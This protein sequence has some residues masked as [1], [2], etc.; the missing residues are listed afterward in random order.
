MKCAGE[1]GS[2]LVEAGLV[3]LPFFALVYLAVDGAWAVFAKATLQHAVREGARYAIT[4]QTS[5]GSGQV[6]SIKA[7][8]IDRALGLLSGDQAGTLFVRF[9]DPVT[10]ADTASNAGGNL[11]EVSVENYALRPVVPLFHSADPVY[12]TVR[13]ADRLEANPGGVP[14]TP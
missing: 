8:V 6:E 1:R 11:V 10:L 7:V 14:P 5:G 2:Q 3:L 4:G 12:V 13:A 9:L